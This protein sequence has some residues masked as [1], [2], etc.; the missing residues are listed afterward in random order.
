MV[1]THILGQELIGKRIE[2]MNKI[3]IITTKDCEACSILVQNA[4]E[5][6]ATTS[7]N[8]E[9]IVKDKDDVNPKWLKANRIREYPT[10]LIMDDD[11]ILS[12]KTGCYPA[13]VL[14]RWIDIHFKLKK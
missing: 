8:V 7:K 5:A 14:L 1:K 2:S 4:R 11:A 3:K 10:I 13:I 6:V 12:R 9:L